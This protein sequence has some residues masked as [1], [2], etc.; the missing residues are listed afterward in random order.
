MLNIGVI[1][2]PNKINRELKINW[3]EK[4]GRF[5]FAMMGKLGMNLVCLKAP[6]LVR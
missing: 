5:L 1:L 6:E 2:Y 3:N 4:E